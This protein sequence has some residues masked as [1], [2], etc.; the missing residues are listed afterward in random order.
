MDFPTI[1]LIIISSIL[2]FII[3]IDIVL[4]IN[5]RILN[6]KILKR[7]NRIFSLLAQQYDLILILAKMIKEEG[8]ELPE[9]LLIS[10]N[11]HE[12]QKTLSTMER[13]NIKTA[14]HKTANGLILVGETTHLK[15]D[16]N[17]IV[18]KSSLNSFNL[19]YRKEV[20]LYNQDIYAYNYWIHFLL[21]RL[22]SKIF[23]MQKKE[24]IQ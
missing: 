8:V 16:Q 24:Y 12:Q 1:I 13:L 19:D 14:I 7:D 23:R 6:K 5:I 15:D 18:I 21:F 17:F 3:F 4:A 10:L 11:L 22:F 20:V 9:D 2:I